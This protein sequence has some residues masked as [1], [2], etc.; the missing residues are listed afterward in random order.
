MVSQIDFSSA[1][2]GKSAS[3]LP[4]TNGETEVQRYIVT[5]PTSADRPVPE[6]AL[7]GAPRPWAGTTR[8]A[9]SSFLAWKSILML[10]AWC[11][12][13]C[14]CKQV[15]VCSQQLIA[16]LTAALHVPKLWTS[17]GPEHPGAILHISGSLSGFIASVLR[18][19]PG[20][21]YLEEHF[22]MAPAA[23]LLLSP[24]K[25]SA[26]PCSQG[27]GALPCCRSPGREGALQGWLRYLPGGQWSGCEFWQ[28]GQ[29]GQSLK[30]WNVK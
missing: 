9:M 15:I 26:S 17:Q 29:R 28:P 20:C 10:E 4:F 8:K 24:L 7:C 21:Q 16:E 1:F 3:C 30:H 25:R 23:L 18:A 19:L 13:M 5:H 27:S 12:K 2:L 22:H 14:L 6:L 11:A